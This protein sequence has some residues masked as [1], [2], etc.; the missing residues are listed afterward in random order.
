VAYAANP[1]REPF[2]LALP[3]NALSSVRSVAAAAGRRLQNLAVAVSRQMV[4]VPSAVQTASCT[5]AC[6]TG[7]V[8][9]DPPFIP[10]DCDWDGRNAD[11]LHGKGSRT[12]IFVR[13]GQYE[14]AETDE[15]RVLTPLGRAQAAEVGRRLAALLD[16]G[17]KLDSVVYSTMTRATETASI[18]RDH[19]G[20]ANQWEPCDL[21]Q[22]GAV[23]PPEPPHT[24]W[25]P[26]EEDFKEDGTRIARAF[27]KY[28]HR[29][30]P[31][32]DAKRTTLYVCHGNVIRCGRSLAVSSLYFVGPREHDVAARAAVW[33]PLCRARVDAAALTIPRRVAGTL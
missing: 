12:L 8:E 26:T 5:A 24:T 28:V 9:Y 10:W 30:E 33:C 25:L 7:G 13:H 3:E 14:W 21:I 15:G 32:E 20:G 2:A 27:E 6:S 19:L 11:G 4:T 1:Q 16:D 22:E 29:S 18:I 31:G 23:Y 17:S